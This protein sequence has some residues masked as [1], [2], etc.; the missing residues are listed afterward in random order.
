[1]TTEYLNNELKRLNK[2]QKILDW[3]MMTAIGSTIFLVFC[4]WAYA[5]FSGQLATFA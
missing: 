5:Y 3:A 2:I 1:M 4:I